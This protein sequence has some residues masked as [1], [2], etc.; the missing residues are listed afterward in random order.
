MKI[1]SNIHDLKTLKYLI[2]VAYDPKYPPIK[3]GIRV[4]WGCS[5]KEKTKKDLKLFCT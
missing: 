4:L 5:R 3:K 2:T 1:I